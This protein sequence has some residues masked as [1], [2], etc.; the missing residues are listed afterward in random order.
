VPRYRSYRGVY[1]YRP[2]GRCY[3]GYG[4]YRYDDDAYKWLAFTAIT[5]KLLDNFNEAQQRQHEAAQVRAT[6]APIGETIEWSDGNASGA[7]TAVREGTSSAGRYCREFRQEVHIGG[8]I[9]Q[10]YGTA[11][12]QPDGSWQMVSS[13]S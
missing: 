4:W 2:Y 5:L 10:A 12:R 8:K 9:E 3:A 11:C 13:G 7:V 1:V 6:T